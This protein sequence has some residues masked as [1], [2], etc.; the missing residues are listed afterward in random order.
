MSVKTVDRIFG[1]CLAD[2]TTFPVTAK[3]LVE[4]DFPDSTGTSEIAGN[5]KVLIG[6][7]LQSLEFI[8]QLDHPIYPHTKVDIVHPVADVFNHDS[9]SSLRIAR[10]DQRK[11]RRTCEPNGWANADCRLPGRSMPPCPQCFDFGFVPHF[12]GTVHNRAPLL[13]AN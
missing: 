7:S 5:V 9:Q 3:V 6:V 1:A 2:D 13:I 12:P 10:T 11:P 4:S 8:D